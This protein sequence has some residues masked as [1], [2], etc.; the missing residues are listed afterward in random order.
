[1]ETEEAITLKI[2]SIMSLEFRKMKRN[3]RD[4]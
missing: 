3:S 1:M 4:E 2:S